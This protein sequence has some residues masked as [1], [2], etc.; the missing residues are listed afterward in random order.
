VATTRGSCLDYFAIKICIPAH[1]C[2]RADLNKLVSGFNDAHDRG[3]RVSLV[4][5]QGGTEWLIPVSEN[6]MTMFPVWKG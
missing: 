5:E 4:G 6:G 3:L 2:K 1:G